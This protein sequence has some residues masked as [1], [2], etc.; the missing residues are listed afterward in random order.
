MMEERR[1]GTPTWRNEIEIA[2]DFSCQYS[3]YS[4]KFC[5]LT[6]FFSLLNRTYAIV[7]MKSKLRAIFLVKTQ[8]AV[9]DSV[10]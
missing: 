3:K 8:S 1:R 7:Q 4:S 5:H 6:I 2:R 9:L 10:I